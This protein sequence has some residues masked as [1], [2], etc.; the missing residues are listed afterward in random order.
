MINHVTFAYILADLDSSNWFL[1][2]THTPISLS[3]QFLEA[4]GT[5]N[6]PKMTTNRVDVKS[7]AIEKGEFDKKMAVGRATIFT[8]DLLQMAR[9][10]Q[11]IPEV[12]GAEEAQSRETKSSGPE[13]GGEDKEFEA[14][15]DNDLEHEDEKAD[16]TNARKKASWFHKVM[17]LCTF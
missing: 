1:A 17:A 3:E 15:E 16:E 11:D 9:A 14:E 5:L 12:D 2:G 8:Q 10:M 7:T 13:R 4:D 6:L